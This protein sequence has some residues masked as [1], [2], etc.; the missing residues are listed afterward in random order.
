MPTDAAHRFNNDL[1]YREG[2]HESQR[3]LTP[4]KAALA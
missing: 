4:H 2:D 1:R 3:Q